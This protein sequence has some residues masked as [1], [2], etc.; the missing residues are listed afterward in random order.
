MSCMLDKEKKPSYNNIELQGYLIEELSADQ[1]YQ[2]MN[3][4][5]YWFRRGFGSW[6]SHP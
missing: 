2:H 5:L 3:Q 1:S 4:G 6:R